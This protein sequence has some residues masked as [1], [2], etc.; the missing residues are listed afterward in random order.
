MCSALRHWPRCRACV[1]L[2]RRDRRAAVTTASSPPPTSPARGC[3]ASCSSAAPTV[4]GAAVSER[5]VR[6]L[7]RARLALRLPRQPAAA[8]DRRRARAAACASCA[9][10][11]SSYT[12]DPRARGARGLLV[13]ARRP[14]RDAGVVSGGHR[15]RRAVRRVGALPRDG[16]ARRAAR[17][18]DAARAAALA[19]R[20][21]PPRRRRR[22]RG[23]RCSRR[24]SPRPWSAALPDDLV[25]GVVL[26]DALI[27]TFAAADD[28]ALRQNRCFLYHAIGGGTGDWDVP[29]GGIGAL[30]A[31]LHDAALAAGAEVR[32]GVEVTAIGDGEVRFADRAR[33]RVVGRRALDA[34]QRRARRARPPARPHAPRASRREGSQL[35]VNLLLTPPAAP[36][37]RA[38]RPPSA[39]SPAPSTSTRPPSSCGA[40][41][42]RRRRRPDPGA[43][44]RAR[45][46]ATR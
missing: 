36:A 10:A 8:A 21:A 9:A 20:A 11:V 37:R 4:G 27:G 26:T 15:R 34:G 13:A 24:R 46:T 35:K 17:V 32:T 28:P 45:R 33:R 7:R 44:R 18:P 5:R 14:G 12:P 39:R 43:R 3:R 31:A 16:A 41:Y 25:R 22:W 40:A 23:R 38:G 42:A 19:R 1:T 29:L 6:R 30:T 2:R